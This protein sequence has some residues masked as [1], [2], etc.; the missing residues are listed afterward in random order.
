MFTDLPLAIFACFVRDS[1]KRPFSKFMVGA[2]SRMGAS[3]MISHLGW[4]LI[5]ELRLFE[6]LRYLEIL[7]INNRG[8]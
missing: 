5:R 8:S 2:Y 6:A 3:Q 4:A 7:K 1:N